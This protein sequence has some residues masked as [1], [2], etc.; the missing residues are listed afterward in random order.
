MK[1]GAVRGGLSFGK[2]EERYRQWL[3]NGGR[4]QIRAHGIIVDWG[5][6][7]RPWWA[8]G[9]RHGPENGS[10]ET[11]APPWLIPPPRFYYRFPEGESTAD[12][13]NRVAIFEDNLLRDIRAVR[14]LRDTCV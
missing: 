6:A 12:V 14:G 11:L 5:C 3:V 2:L 4:L 1:T 10:V 7:T 8:R 13:Y 9:G